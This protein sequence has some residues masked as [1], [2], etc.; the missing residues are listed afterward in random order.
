MVKKDICKKCHYQNNSN[1][2]NVV[3]YEL[4][5]TMM[6]AAAVAAI[7]LMPPPTLPL[8]LFGKRNIFDHL[9]NLR[10]SYRMSLGHEQFLNL[11]LHTAKKSKPRWPAINVKRFYKIFGILE[12]LLYEVY[13]KVPGLC[14]KRNSGLITQFWLPSPSK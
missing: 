13:Q 8:L 9:Q 4:V 11:S 12:F 10:I 2:S 1:S 7:T 14:Q 6:T 3:N 5:L